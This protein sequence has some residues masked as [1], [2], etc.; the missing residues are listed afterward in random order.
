MTEPAVSMR[1]YRKVAIALFA[2]M[3]ATI[4]VAQLHLGSLSLVFAL[5]IAGAKALLVALFFMHLRHGS[6][7]SRLFAGAGLFWLAILLGFT[8]GDFV[9]RMESS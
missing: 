7:V 5:A 6:P 4:L 8:L 9:S 3:A 1:T 2:L